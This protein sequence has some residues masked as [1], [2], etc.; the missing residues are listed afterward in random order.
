[1]AASEVTDLIAAMRSGEMTLEEVA[2]R[3]RQRT[4][5]RTRGPAAQTY[6]QMAEAALLDPTANV[7]GSVDELTAAYDRRQIT[8][9]QYRTL[10]HAVA[11]SINAAEG[12]KT[13]YVMP[14]CKRGRGLA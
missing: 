3:F 11:D 6:T 8:R 14:P 1:M 12:Q 13:E 7:P 5:P 10:A 2:A 4:W 9:E